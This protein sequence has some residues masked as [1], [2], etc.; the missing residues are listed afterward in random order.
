MFGLTKRRRNEVAMLDTMAA[1]IEAEDI[2]F[3]ILDA[4]TDMVAHCLT[5]LKAQRDELTARITATQEDL[6]QTEVSLAAMQ[7]AWDTLAAGMVDG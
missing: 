7:A 4:H 6:R 1:E 5:S 3:S 2:S